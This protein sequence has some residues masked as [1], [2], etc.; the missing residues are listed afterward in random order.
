MSTRPPVRLPVESVPLKPQAAA[1]VD[2]PI[3]ERILS[4]SVALVSLELSDVLVAGVPP[5]RPPELTEALLHTVNVVALEP[6]PIAVEVES[7]SGALALVPVP[8]VLVPVR[9]GHLPCSVHR[10][11]DI[12]SG[13]PPA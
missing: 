4:V 6:V 12:V 3:G 13:V 10:I 11:Q 8:G 7:V 5:A 1:A 9:E 2:V